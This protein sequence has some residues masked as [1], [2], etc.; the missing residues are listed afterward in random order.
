[1]LKSLF[2]LALI[3]LLFAVVPAQARRAM[4]PAD[5]LRVASLSD[6]E[7]SPDGEWVVYTVST[8]DGNQTVSTLWLVRPGE[9]FFRI[10][11][12][13]RPP[14]QRRNPEIPITPGR[15]LMPSGWNAGNPRWSP[16]G[17]SIAFVSTHEER[18]GIWV[19]DLAGR[20]PRFVAAVRET[21]FFITY[22]GESF[23]WSP[24]SKMIAYV[25]A[26]EEPDQD[27]ASASSRNDD[28]RVI[29]RIQYKSR[30]SFSD[31]ARTH[32]WI[33]DVDAPQ[34]RQLTM[35]PFYEHALSFSPSGDEIAFL[36]NHETD[37]DANNNS[38]IFAVDLHGQ[39]RQITNTRG[40]EYE[41]TWSPDG[42]WIAYTATK[43]D[44]TTFDSFAE[45]EHVWVTAAS[46]NE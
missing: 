16:D 21:N 32:V 37:P 18:H 42:K 29:D 4:M 43:R 36:S 6:A 1:M 5:I 41:P 11:P 8:T 9:R 22:A 25:S 10:P 27:L 3:L 35:G 13:G 17:K 19:T 7:V 30:T 45:D 46:G 33:T 20:S 34:P 44:V 39:V 15:Q 28:P 38:D 24:D 31:R 40:C 26:S 2:A 14:E 23:S 12:S